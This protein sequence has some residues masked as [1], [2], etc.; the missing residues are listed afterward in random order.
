MVGR[1]RTVHVARRALAHAGRDQPAELRVVK[2]AAKA[3]AA[4]LGLVVVLGGGVGLVS[5]GRAQ[6]AVIGRELLA[7][8]RRRQLVRLGV[9]ARRQ[10]GRRLGARLGQRDELGPGNEQHGLD[11]GVVSVRAVGSPGGRARGLHGW[12]CCRAMMATRSSRAACQKGSRSK[13][14]TRRPPHA[15]LRERRVC[16][17]DSRAGGKGVRWPGRLRRLGMGRRAGGKGA[18]GRATVGSVRT[19]WRRLDERVGF[20]ELAGVA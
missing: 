7:L 9:P 2:L 20:R 8:G 19:G 18:W 13:A 12:R 10:V 16:W 14:R 4:R 3:D 15:L 6:V 5:C 1:R 17:S 11:G